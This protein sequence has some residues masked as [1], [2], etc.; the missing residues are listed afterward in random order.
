MHEILSDV[1]REQETT[2]QIL[3]CVT[4]FLLNLEFEI[5]TFLPFFCHIGAM[6]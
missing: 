5:S 4:V 2:L 3:Y 6:S 1:L